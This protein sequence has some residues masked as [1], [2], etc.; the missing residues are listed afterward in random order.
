MALMMRHKGD[1]VARK[2]KY[3]YSE[4]SVVQVVL[5]LVVVMAVVCSG[6]ESGV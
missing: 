5:V 3:I 2:K 1:T 4:G 6:D